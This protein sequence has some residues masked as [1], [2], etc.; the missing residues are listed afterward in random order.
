MSKILIFLG[1]LLGCLAQNAEVE[2]R[3]ILLFQKTA[4]GDFAVEGKNFTV[5]YKLQNIGTS[6]AV[7][8]KT[9]DL[10]DASSFTVLEGNPNME[11]EEIAAGDSEEFTV[12]VVPQ[13]AGIYEGTRAA[14]Q[15]SYGT[16]PTS[17]EED[18]GGEEGEEDEEE[19][20]EIKVGY[21]STIGRVEIV[22]ADAYLRATS[23]YVLE[24]TVFVIGFAFPIL[25]P[26][27]MWQMVKASTEKQFGKKFK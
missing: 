11:F 24:W 23:H 5:T 21:S 6:A 2:D 27:I 10:Y 3:A 7:D 9:A 8:V 26:L 14:V 1:L 22:T 17:G 15:Y 19:E 13:V 20:G 18:Q 25:I 4:D 16:A 12:T